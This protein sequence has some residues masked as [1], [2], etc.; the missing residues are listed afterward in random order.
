MRLKLR[1]LLRHPCV[2]GVVIAWVCCLHWNR[3]KKNNA[4][5]VQNIYMCIQ[6]NK[7]PD[8]S[9]LLYRCSCFPFVQEDILENHLNTNI[10]TWGCY[11]MFHTRIPGELFYHSVQNISSS[12]LILRNQ[13]NKIPYKTIILHVVCM[14]HEVNWEY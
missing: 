10:R 6:N 13:K 3:K 5:L 14:G 7:D 11:F 8:L 1:Q 12:H 2:V 9:L 4:S